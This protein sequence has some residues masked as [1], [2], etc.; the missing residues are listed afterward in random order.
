MLSERDRRTLADIERHL[1]ED[2]GLTDPDAELRQAGRRTKR[3]C[4]ALIVTS[5]VLMIVTTLLGA[6][7]GALESGLLAVA[8]TLVLSHTDLVDR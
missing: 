7:T 3:V 8:A 4:M 5:L 1:R 2:G 6:A